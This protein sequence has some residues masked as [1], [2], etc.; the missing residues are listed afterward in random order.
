VA[1]VVKSM[2]EVNIA[3]GLMDYGAGNPG[4]DET[5]CFEPLYGPAH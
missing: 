1:E 2:S 5:R 4:T 3:A